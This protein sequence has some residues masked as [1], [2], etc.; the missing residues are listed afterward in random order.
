M[1]SNRVGLDLR[2]YEPGSTI[3]EN[4]SWLRSIFNFKLWGFWTFMLWWSFSLTLTFWLIHPLTYCVWTWRIWIN[5]SN[6]I[7]V[8]IKAIFINLFFLHCFCLSNIKNI[9]PCSFQIYIDFKVVEFW[10]GGFAL[11]DFLKR[12]SFF[13]TLTEVY[14]ANGDPEGRKSPPEIWQIN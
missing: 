5:L 13:S 8:F 12:L 10:I 1:Q 7:S 14:L 4:A 6:Y 11:S 2:L 9:W 3:H